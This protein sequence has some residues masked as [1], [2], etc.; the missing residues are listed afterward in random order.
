M[1]K[2]DEQLISEFKARLES[3]KKSLLKRTDE[4]KKQ[5]PFTDTDR[6]ND[7]ASDDTEASE[8]SGHERMTALIEELN[9]DVAD[10]TAALGRIADGTYGIC[11]NCGESIEI[12]RLRIL[13]TATLCLADEKKK[14]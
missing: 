12:E 5:D 8:L 11:T 6:V 2:L 14:P 3:E 4:L 9:K 10:I 13:P 7:N 1:Q